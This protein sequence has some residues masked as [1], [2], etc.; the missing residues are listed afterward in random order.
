MSK[1]KQLPPSHLSRVFS[2]VSH[3]PLARESSQASRKI[4]PSTSISTNARHHILTRGTPHAVSY[5]AKR[6]V[7][8]SNTNQQRQWETWLLLYP[9]LRD[10][11]HLSATSERLLEPKVRERRGTDVR[12][13]VGCWDDAC[14]SK[15]RRYLILS[16]SR[17]MMNQ[18]GDKRLRCKR[19]SIFKIVHMRDG[20]QI[21]SDQISGAGQGHL[22]SKRTHLNGDHAC[23]MYFCSSVYLPALL[24][25]ALRLVTDRPGPGPIAPADD[26]QLNTTTYKDHGTTNSCRK[27]RD[28]ERGSLSPTMLAKDL[29]IYSLSIQMEPGVFVGI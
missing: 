26:V 4:P 10:R 21:R 22:R 25:C 14:L 3:P 27:T 13:H 16:G 23:Q 15:N 20:D 28:G 24:P 19:L 2:E 1:K 7:T 9:Y 18:F 17:L 11:L 6:R 5:I 29:S 8:K 12:W